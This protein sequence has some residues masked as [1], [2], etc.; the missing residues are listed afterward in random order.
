MALLRRYHCSSTGYT[1]WIFGNHRFIG[2]TSSGSPT[3]S[4]DVITALSSRAKEIMICVYS[5][6]RMSTFPLLVVFLRSVYRYHRGDIALVTRPTFSDASA[7]WTL[8]R[9]WTNAHVGVVRSALWDES[10]RRCSYRPA[11]ISLMV[12]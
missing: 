6:A 12:I 3:T 7:P 9:T 1:T 11:N 2:K 8:E 5:P 10:V 4:L